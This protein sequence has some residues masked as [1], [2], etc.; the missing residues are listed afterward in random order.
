MWADTNDGVFD[1]TCTCI[2][3]L[4]VYVQL[5]HNVAEQMCTIICNILRLIH[6]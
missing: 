2:S 6:A 3:K 4:T 5:V 1:S